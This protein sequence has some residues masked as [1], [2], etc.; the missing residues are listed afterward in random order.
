MGADEMIP[1]PGAASPDADRNDRGDRIEPHDL[2]M[3]E[4]GV[5]VA[6]IAAD[7]RTRLRAQASEL[8]GRSPLLQYVD[9]PTRAST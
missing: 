4:P 2:R 7:E 9:A 1:D 5:R 3:S 6:H 8:G